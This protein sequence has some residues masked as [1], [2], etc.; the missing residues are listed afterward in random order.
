MLIIIKTDKYSYAF[1]IIITIIIKL[2]NK[3][4]NNIS[5]AERERE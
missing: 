1:L 3:T 2:F 5:I 4:K